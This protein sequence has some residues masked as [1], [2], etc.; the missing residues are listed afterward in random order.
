MEAAPGS[1][2]CAASNDA[3]SKADVRYLKMCPDCELK[4]YQK[5]Y[6][7]GD[8]VAVRHATRSWESSN[9][10]GAAKDVEQETGLAGRKKEKAIC[11]YLACEFF[12]VLG[13]DGL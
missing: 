12:E 11:V 3:Q 9:C 6:R 7:E 4:L 10:L 1:S 8:A 5:D 2:T 13:Q